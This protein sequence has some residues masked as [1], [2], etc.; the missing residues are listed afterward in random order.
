MIDRISSLLSHFNPFTSFEDYQKGLQHK[1]VK[2]TVSGPSRNPGRIPTAAARFAL[3]LRT[4]RVAPAQAKARAA[5]AAHAQMVAQGNALDS[6]RWAPSKL[7]HATVL[8]ALRQD[9]AS[10][11]AERLA[12]LMKTCAQ[13]E[14]RAAGVSSESLAMRAIGTMMREAGMDANACSSYSAMI[15]AMDERLLLSVYDRRNIPDVGDANEDTARMAVKGNIGAR[16][17]SL[18]EHGTP[19]QLEKFNQAF[20]LR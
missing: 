6:Q 20:G 8:L 15:A 18:A 1:E 5:H 10:S 7:A 17:A 13:N 14:N 3:T 9:T 4:L 19:E 16:A 12:N 11:V 2:P